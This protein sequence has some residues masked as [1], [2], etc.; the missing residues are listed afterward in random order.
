MIRLCDSACK[1]LVFK[2]KDLLLYLTTTL[3]GLGETVV[4]IINFGVGSRCS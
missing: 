2:T 3:H 1:S 4:L